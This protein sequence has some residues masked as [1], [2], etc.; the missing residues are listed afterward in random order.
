MN[1]FDTEGQSYLE[2]ILVLQNE[3]GIQEEWDTVRSVRCLWEGNLKEQ[4]SVTLMVGMLSQEIVT[5]SG[6]TAM[7][8]LDV[9]L[10]R[11]KFI[12]FYFILSGVYI[13]SSITIVNTYYCTI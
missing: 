2:N 10:G 8:K 9:L 7:A 12:L 6:D 5:F 1:A 13:L 4:L 11:G 3:L